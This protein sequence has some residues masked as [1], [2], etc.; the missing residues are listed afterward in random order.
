MKERELKQP[1][2]DEQVNMIRVNE[3]DP[4]F[5]ELGLGREQNTSPDMFCGLQLRKLRRS[6]GLN[7]AQLAEL[8]GVTQPNI[9]RWEAG[10][11]RTPVRLKDKLR[12]ILTG[13]NRHAGDYYYRVADSDPSLTAFEVKQFSLPIV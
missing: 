1:G 13:H 10:F 3:I 11:E 9:S 6:R 4:H 7:Q 2:L 12:D 5:H 8:L